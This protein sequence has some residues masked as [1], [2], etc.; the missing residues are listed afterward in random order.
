MKITIDWQRPIPL[1]SGRREGLIYTLDL[2]QI[3]RLPGIYLFARR[4]SRSFEALYVGQST[5]LRARVRGT[6]T[7]CG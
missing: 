2:E 1:R 6:S 3:E 7:T 5:N 4:W